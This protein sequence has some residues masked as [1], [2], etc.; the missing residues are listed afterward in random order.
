[1]AGTLKQEVILK[2]S[3]RRLMVSAII[4]GSIAVFCVINAFM[5]W[6]NKDGQWLVILAGVVALAGCIYYTKEWR[7]H[8]IEMIL[9][10]EG[11]QMRVKGFYSWSSIEKFSIDIDEGTVTL[12]LYIKNQASV[13]FEITSL[14]LKRKELIEMLLSY[15]QPSGLIYTKH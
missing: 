8:K 15:G 14:E 11:L 9:T 1:M 5:F 7:D 6:N 4:T 13:H 3:R 10:R 2:K 12:I